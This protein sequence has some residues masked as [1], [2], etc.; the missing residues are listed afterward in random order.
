MYFVEPTAAEIRTALDI[1]HRLAVRDTRRAM[2]S[3]D[4]DGSANH[5]AAEAYW[6]RERH[7]KDAYIVVEACLNGE[8]PNI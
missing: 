1:I 5:L 3:E 8:L 4:R 7:L 6:A 2:E